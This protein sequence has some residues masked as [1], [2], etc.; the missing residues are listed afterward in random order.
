MLSIKL[1]L[2]AEMALTSIIYLRQFYAK[3]NIPS[4][5]PVTFRCRGRF[6]PQ[7]GFLGRPAIGWQRTKSWI[8]ATIVVMMVGLRSDSFR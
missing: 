8:W 7:L 5:G 1:S 4:A 2:K 6:C 3:E